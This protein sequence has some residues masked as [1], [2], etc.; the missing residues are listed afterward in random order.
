MTHSDEEQP[1]RIFSAA[2]GKENSPLALP[3]GH[4]QSFRVLADIYRTL[5]AEGYRYAY[6]GNVDNIGYTVS[7]PELAIMAITGAEAGFDFA[8]RTAVDIKGG[9]LIIDQSGKKT[10]ADIGQ[11]ISFSA[12][13]ELEQSGKKILFNCATGLF[14]L[15]A[16]VP[17][18]EWIAQSL[19][20]RVSDQDKD[21]GR[22]S[23]AEQSTWE[24]IALLDNT[25]GFAVEK[26]KRFLAAKLLA[27]TI[28]ASTNQP[29]PAAFAPLAKTL[30]AGLAGILAGPCGLSLNGGRWIIQD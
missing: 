18:L 30:S 14:D 19:P 13:E 17:R 23:Q 26:S 15:Q 28:L 3:G 2:F 25:V 20:V 4:G 22:Y 24:V 10:V 8:F 1:R 5:L 6:L 29:I 9:I 16:L 27:E 12:V 7:A 11:A 21:A